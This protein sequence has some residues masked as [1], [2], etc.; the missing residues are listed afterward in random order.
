MF[1][2]QT[3]F[4]LCPQDT[5]SCVFRLDNRDQDAVVALGIYFL[6]SGLQH[7][8]KILPYLMKLA[9]N[10]HKAIWV[11]EVR[12]Q[13]TDSMYYNIS[14]R[15]IMIRI[16]K[17]YNFLIGI[18]VAERFSFCIHTLLSDI[19]TKSA[20]SRDE[21]FTCQVDCLTVLTN[22]LRN[23]KEKESTFNSKIY[24]CKCTVPVLIGKFPKKIVLF[25]LEKSK[26]K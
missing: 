19:A 13:P 9:K 23:H 14:F 25:Y 16:V 11:D 6:E 2:V 18:P 7:Q 12:K 4:S 26:L 21:I 24:L 8:D 5:G 22:A 3:L 15:L 17:Q 20:S 10:L 1:Q